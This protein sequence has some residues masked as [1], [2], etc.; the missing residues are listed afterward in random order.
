MKRL[1]LL[2]QIK[3]HFSEDNIRSIFSNDILKGKAVNFEGRCFRSYQPV[4]E[5]RKTLIELL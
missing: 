3:L 1:L 4:V 5:L 2:Y